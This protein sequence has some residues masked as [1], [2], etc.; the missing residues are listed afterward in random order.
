M[1]DDVNLLVTVLHD[2]RLLKCALKFKR[3]SVP[4][5]LVRR[6]MDWCTEIGHMLPAHVKSAGPIVGIEEIFEVHVH[7]EG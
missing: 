4:S 5:D 3:D 1:G 7:E 6:P 2:E